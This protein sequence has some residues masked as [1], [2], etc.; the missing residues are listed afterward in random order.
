MMNKKHFVLGLDGFSYGLLEELMKR[1]KMKN[2]RLFCNQNDLKSIHSIY[3]VI[4]SVAW[5]SYATG[6]NPGEHNI[7]GFVDRRLQPFSLFIP[8]AN[9]RK[10]PTIW[11]KLSKCN[12]KVVVLNVPLTYPVIK[13]NGIMTSCFLTPSLNKATYPK[14]FYKFLESR[15]YELDVD[16]TIAQ[17][18]KARFIRELI[19]IMQ[20]RFQVCYDLLKKEEWDFFQLHIMETDRL[21]HFLWSEIM[22]RLSNEYTSLLDEFFECLDLNIGKLY[23][24]LPQGT[25]LTILSD[26]G[27]CGI[28]NEVQMNAWLE[29][30][31]LLS[32]EA[33]KEKTLANYSKETIC[34]SILP[35]RIYI[36]L[37]GREVKGSIEVA[38]YEEVRQMIK[39]KLL[40]MRS[41]ENKPVIDKV[42]YREDIYVGSQVSYAA[43]IIAHPVNGYDLKGQAGEQ[44]F[45]RSHLNGMHTYEDAIIISNGLNL[46]EIQ[47]ITDVGEAIYKEMSR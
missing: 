27:F 8:T 20:A 36:N 3:P 33:N 25:C 29:K 41:P 37:K 38:Q 28:K 2:L 10:Y 47:S 9:D 17:Y 34:Y 30:E 19:R 26:H 22:D 11:E 31:G 23:E 39:E 42:F 45:T 7:Y 43:D 32:Y 15:G 12:K 14:D 4:S 40:D 1:E 13:V 35:G 24:S 18:D 5:T 6:V 46:G 16:A 44:I 21:F